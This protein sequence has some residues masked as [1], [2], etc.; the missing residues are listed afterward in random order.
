M[1]TERR[2]L[3]VLLCIVLCLNMLPIWALAEDAEAA[4]PFSE[5]PAAEMLQEEPADNWQE[6]LEEPE[7]DPEE[8]PVIIE[9]GSEASDT[10]ETG[11]DN[12]VENEDSAVKDVADPVKGETDE[13]TSMTDA[14]EVDMAVGEVAK[15]AEISETEMTEGT[16]VETSATSLSDKELATEAALQVEEKQEATADLMNETGTCGVYLTWTLDDAGKLTISGTGE[17][18]DY[19][20]TFRVICTH[21]G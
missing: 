12:S 8:D 3:S 14:G 4:E 1:K 17:M 15:Q 21:G 11:G 6:P 7:E 13:Q 19:Y 10:F 5:E 16:A 20:G 9:T 2:I 18:S